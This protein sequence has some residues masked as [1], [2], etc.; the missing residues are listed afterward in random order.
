MPE[1]LTFA[2]LLDWVEG[3]LPEAEAEQVRAAIAADPQ[4]RTTVAWMRRFQRLRAG[5]VLATP[6]PETRQRLEALFGE[7]ERVPVA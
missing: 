6:P 4:A 1:T 2:T 7:R 5:I 3:R